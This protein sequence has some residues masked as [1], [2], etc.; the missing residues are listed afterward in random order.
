VARKP[1]SPL[2]AGWVIVDGSPMFHRSSLRRGESPR[3]VCQV[4][5]RQSRTAS[6]RRA[7]VPG[8]RCPASTRRAALTTRARPGHRLRAISTVVLDRDVLE[9]ARHVAVLPCSWLRVGPEGPV[10]SPR[11]TLSGRRRT[12]K[13][14]MSRFGRDSRVLLRAKEASEGL[15]TGCGHLPGGL[16]NSGT[17]PL[18]CQAAECRP[19]SSTT[20]CSSKLDSEAAL[21]VEFTK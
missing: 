13:G 11:L 12:P 7:R 17:W 21:R 3:V 2:T 20:V 1:V 15:G 5:R 10:G 19:A 6:T 16:A 18:Q 4:G 8:G 9:V 14:A